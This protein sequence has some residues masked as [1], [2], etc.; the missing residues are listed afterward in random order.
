MSKS[1]DLPVALGYTAAAAPKVM[2]FK[3]ADG[4]DHGAVS[5]ERKDGVT[6]MN[7]K[8]LAPADGQEKVM[9][10]TRNT[11]D[12]ATDPQGNVMF[13]RTGGP[14]SV[15]YLVKFSDYRTVNGVQLP[16][17]W[18]TTTGGSGDETFE[19]TSYDVNPANIDDTFKNEKVMVRSRKN[20]Q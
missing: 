20:G 3:T 16:F 6:T 5:F 2:M 10:F 7:S 11:A 18:T 19:V 4:G 17:K 13:K 1:S 15:D 12:G 8:V 9:T 14:E